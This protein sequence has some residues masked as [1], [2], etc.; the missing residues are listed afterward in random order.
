MLVS[1]LTNAV[2]L[3]AKMA[4]SNSLTPLY[5]SIEL[6]PETIRA[7]SE[8]GNVEIWTGVEGLSV[9]VLLEASSLLAVLTSLDDADEITFTKKDAAVHWRCAEAKG[10]WMTV[11]QEHKI[12]AIS[13]PERCEW[14]PPAGFG[15]ALLVAG[16]ACTTSAVSI[17]LYGVE[18]SLGSAEEG[19]PLRMISSNSVALAYTEISGDPTLGSLGATK[20]T[21]RPPIPSIFAHIVESTTNPTIAFSSTGIFI[22]SEELVALL[23]V[24]APLEHDLLK[25][26]AKYSNMENMI[27][28]NVGALKK[29]LNRARTLADKKQSVQVGLR[30]DFGKLVLE[31]R[32]VTSSAEEYFLAEGID[33]TVSYASVSLPL[34]MLITPLAHVDGIVLDYLPQKILIM[35][36]ADYGFQYVLGGGAK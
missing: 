5:R 15:E 20:L 30:V 26:L 9:P 17:G 23:P 36:G 34:D 11:Q 7:C 27:D 4:N 24:A 22:L 28:V 31:H 14:H 29:F 1:T 13:I 35:V 25:V 10:H 19:F 6:G 2:K 8:F 12:P 18:L 21:L 3:A 16:S 33:E 32:G